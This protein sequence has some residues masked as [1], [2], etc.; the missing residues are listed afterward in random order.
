[1][2]RKEKI[3]SKLYYADSFYEKSGHVQYLNA[4]AEMM[5]KAN[6]FA[7]LS[8]TELE[9]FCRLLK[10]KL[11]ECKITHAKN[12]TAYVV[13]T[14]DD[15]EF[16][17]IQVYQSEFSEHAVLKLY[18]SPILEILEYDLEARAFFDVSD[19]LD[20]NEDDHGKD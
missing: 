5:K 14:S 17:A 9:I 6:N 4:V 16:G 13:F 20:I 19:R 11:D 12:S 18:I 2:S 10:K 3:M 15:N 8:I 7:F 1:M